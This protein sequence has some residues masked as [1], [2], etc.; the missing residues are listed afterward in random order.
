MSRR[1]TLNS[2]ILDM[3]KTVFI[4]RRPNT[5]NLPD[6]VYVEAKRRIG[7]VYKSGGDILKGLTIAEQKKWLPEILG[8]SPTDPTWA[9]QVKRFYANLTID[10]PQ[11]GVTLNI[12]TDEEGNPINV[13]DFVKYK[14]ALDHPH[15]STDQNSS[16]GRYF[17]SDPQ[18]EE[19][20]AV[21]ST[22][23]RKDA[24]KQL[25]LLSE[26]ESKALQVL[27]AYGVRTAGLSSAQIEL[28]LEDLLEEDANEFIRVTTDKN[29]ET[30]SFI[31]DCIEHGVLRKSG[32]TFL[33][34]DEVLGDDMEQ[35]VRF[36]NNKKNSSMLLDI[37]AKL[38]AFS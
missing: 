10:V 33:F 28:E 31:W 17:I 38:K 21:S 29:L 27:K 35:A 4:Y 18:K 19:A 16:R 15:V 5:T 32:N 6:D 12:A 20:A 13:M 22:R 36:L 1:G 8:I 11:E 24:Y 23:H 30:V 3:Q 25:I 37:K 14:F 7:S 34:G 2:K 9:R 26:D